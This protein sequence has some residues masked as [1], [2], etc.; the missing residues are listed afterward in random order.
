MK[1]FCDCSGACDDCLCGYT[2]CLAGHGDDDFIKL[3]KNHIPNILKFSNDKTV[4]RLIK[5]HPEYERA[6][7][8]YKLKLDK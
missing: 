2:G 6:I 8:L 1:F 7:K 5:N 4:N 3:T